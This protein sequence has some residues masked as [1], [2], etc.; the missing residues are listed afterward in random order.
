MNIDLCDRDTELS[1]GKL[2]QENRIK[3]GL[4]LETVVQDTKISHPTL[5]AIEEGDYAY[6]PATVFTKGFIAL[7]AK[8]LS[9]DPTETLAIY[10]KEQKCSDSETIPQPILPGTK[11][12]EVMGIGGGSSSNYSSWG[13]IIFF[14][15]L[16]GAFL[17]WFFSWNPA[18]FLS[19]KLRSFDKGNAQMEQATDITSSSYDKDLR[20]RLADAK[21]DN[22]P[23]SANIFGS[24]AS[25]NPIY[26][27]KAN[28]Q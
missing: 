5:V 28:R 1:L 27:H 8:R 26:L 6:L 3:L 18:T 13:V 17:C 14:V 24:Q 7:Y 25:N 21:A 11:T 22:K 15:L 4:S 19:Q 20:Y 10:H 9:L 2:L 16:F 23:S 12:A